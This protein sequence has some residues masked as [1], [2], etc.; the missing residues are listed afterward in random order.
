MVI[1]TKE[2]TQIQ[3]YEDRALMRIFGPNKEKVA[4]G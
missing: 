3:V 4:K 1:H 2:T